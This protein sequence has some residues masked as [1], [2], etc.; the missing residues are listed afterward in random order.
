MI[1][2]KYGKP[3]G[4]NK[5]V[6]PAYNDMTEG[7][8]VKIAALEGQFDCHI[9][10]EGYKKIYQF[11]HMNP[12]YVLYIPEYIKVIDREYVKFLGSL[13]NSLSEHVI[14]IENAHTI[15]MY[16]YYIAKFFETKGKA[17]VIDSHNYFH[18]TFHAISGQPMY[19][20]SGLPT[21]LL[22]SLSNLLRWVVGQNYD[23]IVFASESETSYRIDFTKKK[24]GE[25]SENVYKCKRE[26]RDPL[27]VQQI[28]ICEK[29]L[30]D[31]G[32]EV[33]SVE[34]Y[35]GDD[36]M[37]SLSKRFNEEGIEVHVLTSDKDM[38]QLY[39]YE[40][41]FIIEPKTRMLL[42]VEHWVEKFTAIDSKTK[43]PKGILVTPNYFVDY[44]SIIGDATDSVVGLKNSGPVAACIL[45]Q[46]YG[47]LKGL[48]EAVLAGEDTGY[49]NITKESIKD[50]IISRDLVYMRRNLLDSVDIMKFSKKYFNFSD[51]LITELKKY[52]I[53]FLN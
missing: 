51:L 14:Y 10:G 17:L 46:K 29:F 32:M 26:K 47:S 27:L 41:V 28:G 50:A 34:G 16:N 19:S 3:V 4:E 35:E 22:K 33:C 5:I 49:K 7:A 13:L 44:Q 37:A 11:L 24:Y 9:N 21:S 40:N 30:K 12:D 45:L 53:N 36:I 1:T 20:N 31:V 15:N 39:E 25:N 48:C 23:Y 38:Y 42:P 2:I 8:I 6:S 18:K 43:E 52:D